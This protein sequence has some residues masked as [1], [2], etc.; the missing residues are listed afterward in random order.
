ME[1]IERPHFS[2]MEMG[3]FSGSMQTCHSNEKISKKKIFSFII[4]ATPYKDLPKKFRTTKPTLQEHLVQD[5]LRLEFPNMPEKFI[6]SAEET[7]RTHSLRKRFQSAREATGLTIKE[8]AAQLKAPQYHLK[9]IEEMSS[10]EIKQE[11]F[12][13]YSEFLGLE[14]WVFEWVNANKILAAT[15]GLKALSKSK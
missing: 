5:F 8:V 14:D 2:V 6:D 4:S 3:S 1:R 10:S 13:K 15:L 11:I 12:Q 9:A 7:V